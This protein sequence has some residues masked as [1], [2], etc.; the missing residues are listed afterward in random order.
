MELIEGLHLVASGS[1]GFDLTDPFDCHA[2]LVDGGGEAA[3]IDAGIGAA[4]DQLLAG[5]DRAGV[6]RD[7]LRYL[8]LTHA[9]PDHSGGAAAL[10]EALPGL[11]VLASAQVADVVERGDEEAMSLEAGKRAEFYPADFRFTPCPV[12]GRLADGDRIVIGDRSLTAIE[13]P[14]HSAGHL[15]F[16]G[17]VGGRRACFGGD[18]VFYGGLISLE[19]NWD[20]SLQAY[21]SSV[22]R[23]A[24]EPVDALLPGHHQVSLAHGH[25]HLEAAARQFELGF[26]PR[27]VV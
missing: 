5:V 7:R 24:R 8:L 25:R 18:L 2:Y 3:L 15:A 19:S 22:A 11:Q 16:V 23:L 26:V 9:H 20:C 27:S 12:D 21:A 13:T 4:V 14:G 6:E 17:D 1:G 10:K